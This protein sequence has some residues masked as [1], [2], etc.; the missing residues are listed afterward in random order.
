[1]QL[2]YKIMKFLKGFFTINNEN[3]Y[4]FFLFKSKIKERITRKNVN[5]NNDKKS[6]AWI[7]TRL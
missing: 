5:N 7:I 6:A 4:I 2:F 3:V 1:M